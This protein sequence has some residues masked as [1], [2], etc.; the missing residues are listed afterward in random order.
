MLLGE[1]KELYRRNPSGILQRCIPIRQGQE[2]LAEI[3]LG[4]CGNHVAPRTLVGNS[5][6]QGFY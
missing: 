6:M 1:E 3:H 5:F 2:L 4:A